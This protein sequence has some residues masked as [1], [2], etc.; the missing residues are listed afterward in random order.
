MNRLRLISTLK[1]SFFKFNL[2]S[3]F[4]NFFF[5][6]LL[7][8]RYFRFQHILLKKNIILNLKNKSSKNKKLF[9]KKKKAFKLFIKQNPFFKKKKKVK[10]RFD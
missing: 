5:K 4:V 3:N 1:K 6:T 2:K 9:F 10:E 7:N 8:K